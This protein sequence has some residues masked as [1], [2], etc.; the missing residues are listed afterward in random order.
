MS[1]CGIRDVGGELAY[2]ARDAGELGYASQQLVTARDARWP[3]YIEEVLVVGGH[4]GTVRRELTGC[5]W[6]VIE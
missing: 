3:Y 6:G 4:L 5:R 1:V 2:I